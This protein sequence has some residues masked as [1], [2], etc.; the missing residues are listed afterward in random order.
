MHKGFKCLHVSSGQVYISCDVVFDEQVF[1]YADPSQPDSLPTSYDELRLL[2]SPASFDPTFPNNALDEESFSIGNT[3]PFSS[4]A[5]QND[6]SLADVFP[7]QAPTTTSTSNTSHVDHS[8]QALVMREPD[9]GRTGQLSSG[10]ASPVQSTASP[11]AA[12]PVRQTSAEQA[13]DGA[14]SPRLSQ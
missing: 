13:T 14:P 6:P 12:S 2:A 11:S 7:V 8:M 4:N 1:L 10:N 5:L 3:T 9:P